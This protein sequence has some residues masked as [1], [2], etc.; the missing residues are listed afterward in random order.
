MNR[1]NL[2]Q[3]VTQ[4]S[5]ATNSRLG[6]LERLTGGD[7]QAAL[8]LLSQQIQG[9]AMMLSFEQLFLLFGVGMAIGLPLLLFMTERSKRFSVADA[10]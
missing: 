7:V 6:I 9:Q 1:A 2:L 4:Y 3:H 10:H 5:D 8:K